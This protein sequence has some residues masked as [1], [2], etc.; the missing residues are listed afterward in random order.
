ML[1]SGPST[2]QERQ[3][4]ALVL[5]GDGA[6]LAK[7][8]VAL[9]DRGVTAVTASDGV[10]GLE[11]LF[12]ELLS[13]DVLIMALDLPHRDARALARLIRSAGNEHGLALVV[14]A[15]APSPALRAEL[16]AL[17]VDAVVGRREGAA[18]AAAAALD[19]VRARRQVEEIE[20]ETWRTAPAVQPLG[21][22]TWSTAGLGGMAMVA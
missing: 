11:R 3:S 13:L 9:H 15:D 18:A 17:G 19:A 12:E 20:L 7:L 1:H 8:Q 14:V 21:E 10:A 2:Q 6:S 4:R 16:H 5:D 22:I